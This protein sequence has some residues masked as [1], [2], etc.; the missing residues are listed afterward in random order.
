MMNVPSLKDKYR[1]YVARTRAG[2][3]FELQS[4]KSNEVYYM[5]QNMQGIETFCYTVRLLA[6]S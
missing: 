3:C 2:I 4:W 1:T 6:V 5:M